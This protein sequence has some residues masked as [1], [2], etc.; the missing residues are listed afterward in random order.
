[1]RPLTLA[2]LT[3]TALTA[4]VAHA[5][6]TYVSG[7]TLDGSVVCTNDFSSVVSVNAILTTATQHL[8]L[9]ARHRSLHGCRV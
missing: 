3:P 2:A 6:V 8:F 9:P 7:A 4:V 5:D 1:M